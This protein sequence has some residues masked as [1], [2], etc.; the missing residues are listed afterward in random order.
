ME[1]QT[2]IFV[3]TWRKMPARITHHPEKNKANIFFL[4]LLEASIPGP[5]EHGVLYIPGVLSSLASLLNFKL[6]ICNLFHPGG[7]VQATELTLIVTN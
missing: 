7:Q 3:K 2:L 6:S 1:P 5:Q 4:E